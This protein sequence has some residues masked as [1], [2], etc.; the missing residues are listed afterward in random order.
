MHNKISFL[1]TILLVF[2]LQACVPIVVGA[3]VLVGGVIVYD[4]RSTQAMIADKQIM[5]VAQSKLDNNDAIRNK[6]HIIVTSFNQSVLLT[7]QAPTAELRDAAVEIVQQTPKIK[8]VFNEITIEA[9]TD[10]SARSHDAWIT[11]KVKTA[12]LAQKG[13][14]STQIKLVTEKGVVYL[15]GLVTNSQGDLAAEVAKKI[16]GVGKVVKA[17]EYIN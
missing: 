5:S 2:C 9:P 13:L 11:T 16:D 1:S 3:G 4:N 14:H 17:F 8:R 7:G 15:L 12:L 6:A 10:P